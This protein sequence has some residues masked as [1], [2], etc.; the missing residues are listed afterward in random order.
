MKR[1]HGAGGGGK[2]GS[3]SQQTPKEAADNLNSTQYA[4]VLDLISEGEIQGLK[5]GLQSI[6]LDNT[7][8]Q[9]ADGSYNFQNVTVYATNG[10]QTQSYI[11][12]ASDIE[13]PESVGVT[14]KQATPV[15]RTITDSNVN[16]VRLTIN[17]PALQEFTDKGD[18]VGASVQLNIAI[19]YNGGGYT[20]VINDVVKGRTGDLY[21]RD[22]LVNLSGAFPVDIKVTRVTADSASSKLVDAFSWQYFT[23]IVYAKLNY[24][25]SALVGLRVDSE[26]FN[27]I[28][29]R[30][31]LVRG[32]KVKIPNN[33]TVDQINGRLIYNGLWNGI[34]GPAQWTT[35]PTWILWD[36]LINTRY[37]LGDQIQEAQL[38]KWAFYAASQYCNELVY[39]NLSKGVQTS[40]RSIDPNKNY[41]TI[42]GVDP[43][44]LSVDVYHFG[45]G[46]S[47]SRPVIIYIHGGA[48]A[49]GDKTAV[50]SKAQFFN[51][52]GYIFV[53]VNYRLSPSNIL[54]PYSSFNPNRVKHPIHISDCASAV[55][56]VY[57]NIN[58]YGGNR[59]KI[60]LLGHSAGAHLVSL[61]ATNQGYITN[62]GV[63]S[64]A[65]LGTVSV[66]TEGGS[67][68]NQIKNPVSGGESQLNLTSKFYQNAFG[69]Y[70]DASIT[71]TAS[72]ITIDFP[73]I[74]AA[75]ASY[76]TAS[77]INQIT[78]STPPFLVIGRGASDRIAAQQ[79]FVSALQSASRPVTYICYPGDATY[80]H[81]EINKCIGSQLDPPSGKTLPANV[82][83]VSTQI[84]NFVKN[85][86]QAPAPPIVTSNQNLEPRFSCNVNIQTQE[87]TYK[88]INDISSVFR[89]MPYWSTG[90]LT[91]MQDKPADSAY[92]FTLANVSEEG[93][94]YTSSSLKNRPTVAVV[95]YMDLDLRN[96]AYEEV[97]DPDLISKYGVVKS[98]ITAF[99]CTSRGQA[100]R[101]GKWLL[102]SE[103]N[104]QEIISFTASIDAGVLVRPGQII[105]VSDP[106]RAGSRRGG[107]ISSATTTVITIDDATGLTTANAPTLSVILPNGT[108]ETKSVSGISGKAITVS[109]AF[110]AAPNSNSV[111]VFQSTDLKTTQWRVISVIE[112]DD[113][114]YA[115]TAL[116]YNASKYNYI[117]Q[118]IPL[119]ER[120][121]TN[122]NNLPTAPTN[123]M[124]SE[125]LYKY[126]DQVRAKV[127]ASWKSVIGV[128]AYVVKWRKNFGNWT[129]DTVSAPDFEI[130]NTTPGI[131]DFEIYSQSPTFK[132]SVSKLTGS[133][134]ALGKTAP[135]GD[136]PALYAVLDPDVGV[137]LSWDPVTDLDLQGYEIW[138]GPAWGSGTKLGVF[139]ATSKKLGLLTAGTTTWWIKAL[140]TSGSYST[141]ATSTSITIAPAGAPTTSGVFSNDSLIFSWTA[142]AGSLSTAF[143]EVRYGT[144][145]DTWATATALG[146]VLGT[147]YAIKGA[148]VGTQRF[149]VKAVDLKGNYGASATFDAVITAPS[150]PSITQQVID[151]NVLLQWTDSTQTLP[152]TAYEL[153]KGATWASATVIGTKQ[154]K[155]TTVF[156]SFSGTYVYWLAGIDSAGNY[157]TPGSV[158][159]QV[160][161][162]PDYVLK[163][164]QNSAFTGTS[165]NMLAYGTGLLASVNTTETWTTHFTSRSWTSP[166]DQIN[167]GYSYFLMP[168]TTTAQYYEDID[169]G[170][171][172][173]GTKVTTTLTSSVV[174]GSTT[175]TP[176]IS[177]RGTTST[178]ATY[179]QSTT[180]ITVTSTAHGL[181]VGAL[182]YLNFTS[183]TAT[184]G[185]YIVATAATNSFT[186]TSATSATTSGNVS[187]TAWTTYSNISSVFATNFRY[188]RAQYD[189]ASAGGDD[190][191]QLTG[192]NIRLDSK[193]RNDSGTGTAN[194]SDSGGTVVNFNIAF[195]DVDSI[196]V[197]PATTSAVIA[198]YD[199]VDV[200]NPTSFKVLLFNTS[201]TR[202]SGGFSWSARGV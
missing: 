179:S 23:K 125:A 119:Q 154:G 84:I 124:L 168:S 21:Q 184:S 188:I 48:W 71:N 65:I 20:T 80:T 132:L 100:N 73:T 109:S 83:N 140:D 152:I 199:F 102:Y 121:T 59:S 141:T 43:T 34:F 155:F 166:Q 150:Q 116:A 56:W 151:N 24:P 108:V 99:A 169:Y 87:E 103:W 164:N 78:A 92:L 113:A 134:N 2:G 66:D 1:I 55:G 101:L 28:P 202:V 67:V 131:F 40:P 8:L 123:L 90:A 63:P 96:V 12:V 135:P 160:N 68:L 159:A 94:S 143:Y 22:Y 79:S 198:V 200:P 33:A 170:T 175:I 93:F 77:P 105:D 180:T 82:A 32:I 75:E 6:Y 31:Y 61:L 47:V 163:L 161:Q 29:A 70:P 15:V 126:Q 58:N 42:S 139:A 197:T 156:E 110:S 190:L 117:E 177:V 118:S 4:T 186:V 3:S 74:A 44:L 97:E 122:L 85:L 172:L 181:A 18:I 133:I 37:G 114:Q 191:L 36:L 98:E 39:S 183:G 147:T 142:V 193:L 148:W 145:S 195:V 178:S 153:R 27:S 52:N 89:A 187:W 64:A 57:S 189:L 88:V 107:R 144:V 201:G 128:N 149:F 81:P 138:Q 174:A 95:S 35:D 157:G 127:I 171:V 196:S 185:S 17:F 60:I 165:T 129:Q 41:A 104:E 72:P 130:L 69:I 14:V 76:A 120:D 115:V 51:D 26:Q 45:E 136:V 10:T 146:T 111:W 112:Q 19:Q 167:A 5:N 7:S 182:V 86:A 158:S 25:N 46:S 53:S 9:N 173:A 194:S 192:L 30:S 176:T 106:V 137:T 49:F 16:A 91:V 62:A 11:P 50:E 54:L 38:D 13:N 162:P